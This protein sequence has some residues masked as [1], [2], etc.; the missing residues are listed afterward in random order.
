M[1]SLHPAS[2]KI[3]SKSTW[4]IMQFKLQRKQ[5]QDF[6]VSF[7]IIVIYWYLYRMNSALNMRYNIYSNFLTLTHLGRYSV[8]AAFDKRIQ[9]IHIFTMCSTSQEC[10]HSRLYISLSFAV[11]TL[12]PFSR[13]AAHLHKIEDVLCCSLNM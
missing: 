5:R 13:P 2:D 11:M 10:P 7:W 8:P 12:I 3:C 1:V 4:K 6:Y 9:H